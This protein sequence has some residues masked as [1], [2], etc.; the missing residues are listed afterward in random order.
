[1][2]MRCPH[3]GQKYEID[4]DLTGQELECS[5]C[6]KTFTAVQSSPPAA[7]V[8]SPELKPKT[9]PMPEPRPASA[10]LPLPPGKRGIV[11]P[12][13]NRTRCCPM[14]GEE[15]LVFAKKCRFCGEYFDNSGKP[16]NPN[17]RAIYVLLALFLGGFGA[18]NFY[19]GDNKT[20]IAHIIVTII[21]LALFMAIPVYINSWVEASIGIA[22]GVLGLLNFLWIIIEICAGRSIVRWLKSE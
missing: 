7:L 17:N 12:K 10:K 8:S 22:A 16:R 9:A 4:D 21:L 6:G 18:H 13:Q 11:L 1:M 3:C 2:R 14:C 19:E 20:A 5:A 15:I